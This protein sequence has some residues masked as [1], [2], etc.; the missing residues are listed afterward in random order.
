M[1]KKNVFDT[2]PEHNSDEEPHSDRG[3]SA[4]KQGR[5]HADEAVDQNTPRHSKDGAD[6]K[7]SDEE[8]L[9]IRC[10]ERRRD[11]LVCGLRHKAVENQ[12]GR[13]E[14]TQYCGAADLL[15]HGQIVPDLTEEKSC[16]HEDQQPSNH[17][18]GELAGR[19]GKDR[20]Q[21]GYD[22]DGEWHCS[23]VYGCDAS[24]D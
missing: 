6:D 8:I 22:I 10:L 13:R 7:A 15:Q 20:H 21:R 9:E 4:D 3:E 2:P 18:I 24:G 1:T 5:K 14:Q 23:D 11:R 19:Y 17:V 16:E 12:C